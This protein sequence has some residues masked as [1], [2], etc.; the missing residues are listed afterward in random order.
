[1]EVKNVDR[2]GKCLWKARS[3][4]RSVLNKF[5]FDKILNHITI[6]E[7]EKIKQ[8][9]IIDFNNIVDGKKNEKKRNQ[10]LAQI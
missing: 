2:A 6:Q 1:M 7:K 4:P 10:N 3:C 9:F 8:I 5:V